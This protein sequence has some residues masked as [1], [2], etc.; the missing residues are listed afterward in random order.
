MNGRNDVVLVP[1]SRLIFL[2]A[3]VVVPL[4]SQKRQQPYHLLSTTPTR[5]GPLL[6][7]SIYVRHSAEPV[8]PHP[9][10]DRFVTS[11]QMIVKLHTDYISPNSASQISA[12][13][14]IGRDSST[15]N[16]YQFSSWAKYCAVLSKPSSSCIGNSLPGCP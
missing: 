9:Y 10:P 1:D 11:L 15:R 6:V 13:L 3:L 8:S 16:S 2:A 12:Q 5:L 7:N 4:Y 14:I